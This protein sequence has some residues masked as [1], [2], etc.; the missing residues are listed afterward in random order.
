MELRYTFFAVELWGAVFCYIIGISLFSSG[1]DT[2]KSNRMLTVMIGALGIMLLSDSAAWYFRGS[3]AGAAHIIV[4]AANFI[5]Y[6]MNFLLPVLFFFFFAGIIEDEKGRDVLKWIASPV[7]G[8]CIFSLILLVVSQFNGMLYFI[9]EDNYYHRGNWFLFVSVL[10][11]LVL[12]M[13]FILLIYEKK[14]ILPERWPPVFFYI[15][16]SLAAVVAQ[17]FVYGFSFLN[18]M[19]ILGTANLFAAEIKLKTSL[20]ERQE[21]RIGV[22]S[23]E[24]VNLQTRIALS[25][26][27]P[28][29]LY[30]ALNSIYILCGSD[31][32]KGRNAISDLS[33]YLRA[34]IGSIDSV[35]PIPFEKEMEHVNTYMSIEKMRFGDELSFSVIA[36]VKD[37]YLPSLTLQPLVENAVRHGIVPTGREGIILVTTRENDQYYIISISDNGMGFDVDI[38]NEDEGGHIGIKNVRERLKMQM[39]ASLEISS[40]PGSG[41]EITIKVPKKQDN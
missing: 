23:E 3:P 41:T 30:N 21:S 22:Q 4:K 37:F 10:Y 34:S 12:M 27:K 11:L 20:L 25:Q 8:I 1:N 32:E 7:I 38:L 39:N 2:D 29:F 18:I 13:F 26:I 24:I 35:V 36:P 16:A 28:H 17:V 5:A 9:D 19:L 31:L 14:Y 40:I 6:F 33:D 15:T